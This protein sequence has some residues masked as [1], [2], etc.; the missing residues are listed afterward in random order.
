MVEKTSASASTPAGRHADGVATALLEHLREAWRSPTL[1]YSAPPSPIAIGVETWIFGL[2]LENAPRELT[3]PLVLRLFPADADPE[4]ARFEQVVQNAVAG[5]GYPAPR[6]P[7]LCAD[8]ATLGGSFL[9]MERIPGRMM[10]DSL[11]DGTNPL[12]HAPR[13]IVEALSRMPRMLVDEQLRLHSLDAALLLRALEVA[14]TPPRMYRVDGWLRS[15]HERIDAAGLEG[16]RS[17]LAWLRR[18]RPAEPEHLVICHC[19]F[20]PPNLMVRDRRLAGVLDWSHATLADPAWD[21]ANT[22][23]RLAMNPFEHPPGLG[24][25][26]ALVRRRVSGVYLDT[27]RSRRRVDLANVAYYEVLVALW[28]L[29]AVGEHRLSGAAEAGD[30]RGANPWLAPGAAK[31]L[32]DLCR[33][34]AGLELSLPS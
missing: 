31:P 16:L 13:L 12:L 11:F 1:R 30:G 24:P 7:H 29:A 3:G 23:L 18:Q 25:V 10:L 32:L 34:V 4:Q 28:M 5:L 20:L 33:S 19:D 9:I 22:R 26:I 17:A 2:E 21:V 15:L 6:V 8:P 14:G 27:Y